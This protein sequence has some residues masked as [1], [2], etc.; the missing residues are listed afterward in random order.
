MNILK[1]E[2]KRGKNWM[3][4]Q[5]QWSGIKQRI[6]WRSLSLIGFFPFGSVFDYAKENSLVDYYLLLL[7]RKT[8]VCLVFFSTSLLLLENCLNHD[9]KNKTKIHKEMC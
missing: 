9:Y 7:I 4:R 5:K 1:L 2:E 3:V 8:F 6:E